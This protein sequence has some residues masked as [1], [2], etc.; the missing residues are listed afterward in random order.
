MG[1]LAQ[2]D[3]FVLPR[4]VAVNDHRR[5]YPYGMAVLSQMDQEAR[6]DYR[7]AAAAINHANVDMVVI[8][9]EFG[10]YGGE[11]GEYILDLA[12]SLTVPFI[13]ILH[14][15]LLA[16]TIKQRSIVERLAALAA[17]TVTMARNT[18]RDLIEAYH[19]DPSR[20]SVIP[21]GVPSLST[22]TRDTLKRRM[23]LEGRQILSTFGFLS[24]GKGIEYAVAA[25]PRVL[26]RHPEAHYVVLGETHPQ[27]RAAHGETYRLRLLD[28]ARRLHVQERVTF[29]NRFL[30]QTEIVES[31]I[32]SDLC[33]TPYL[34]P[35]QAVSGTLAYNVGYGRAVI[36]TPYRYATELLD[37]GRGAFTGFRDAGSLGT[38]VGELLA[39]PAA[40]QEMEARAWALGRTM[41]WGAV[42]ARYAALIRRALTS[43]PRRLE[44]VR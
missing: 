18:E 9:H 28:L 16:P 42:A 5:R 27:V 32:A 37:G 10:I 19:L 11:A 15:V 20:L 31:L 24:P 25:M 7:L 13:V 41:R 35:E 2:M 8:Q 30:S 6:R 23:G 26:E 12:E 3:E 17:A 34:A 40:R 44:A 22:D 4:M 43:G 33:L 36:S 21:H 29:V 1:E 14:T 38:R 39:N